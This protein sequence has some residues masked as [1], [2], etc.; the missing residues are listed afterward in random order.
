MP[1]G[2]LS[3]DELAERFFETGVDH[4]V[5]YSQVN[6]VYNDGYAWNGLTSVGV[7]PSGGESNKQYADNIPYLNLFSVEEFGATIECFAAPDGFLTYDGVVKTANGMQISQQS[8]PVFGF[9]WR[10]KKGNANDEDLG[11]IHHLAYGLQASPSEKTYNTVNE[12]PE[13]TTFSWTVTSTP[14]VVTG[15]KPS[16]YIKIDSTD[17][18]V[19][20]ANLADLLTVLHGSV[21]VAPRLPLPDEVDSILGT[22][23]VNVTPDPLAYTDVTDTIEYVAQAGVRYW[24]EDTGEEILAD[25]ILGVGES[26]I[27]KATPATGYNFTGAFVDRWLYEYTP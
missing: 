13:L 5:L 20:P 16:A 24:R 12:S 3:W 2:A 6:G 14:V 21:G 9:Y 22:G 25:I 4:G 11:Y 23:I 8:R 17:E 26:L 7:T 10:T 18:T 1:A 15:H 19:D 27:V